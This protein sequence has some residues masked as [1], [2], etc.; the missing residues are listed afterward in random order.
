MAN[1]QL[2]YARE[3]VGG[4]AGESTRDYLS[5]AVL[6]SNYV[7][8]EN[9]IGLVPYF[10][11][12]PLGR[13]GWIG[14]AGA[15][16][17]VAAWLCAV[18]FDMI[19]AG[20]IHGDDSP[21]ARTYNVWGSISIWIGL[22]VLILMTV[23]HASKILQVPEGGCPPFIMTLFIG[24]AQISLLLTLLQMLELGSGGSNDFF[25]VNSSLT[26]QE[27]KDERT[28]VRNTLVW[29]MIAKVYIVNFLKN[30]QEWAGPA[31]ELKKQAIVEKKSPVQE[32]P[33]F[34]RSN[35]AAYA[36]GV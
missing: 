14:W 1:R 20:H 12:G 26:V 18:I 8:T 13:Q 3:P 19:S 21:G 30:N 24:G 22:G 4:A 32:I 17:H 35:T 11:S 25:F 15:M 6:A 5:Q 28:A 7:A 9:R 34:K 2:L 23:L 10:V 27:Q 31:E 36:A 16:L 29:S 33:A